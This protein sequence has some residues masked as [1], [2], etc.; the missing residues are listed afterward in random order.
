VVLRLLIFFILEK[1]ENKN[2]N[3]FKRTSKDTGL[4]SNIKQLKTP[5]YLLVTMKN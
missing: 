2:K 4:V 3:L 1:N 5:G